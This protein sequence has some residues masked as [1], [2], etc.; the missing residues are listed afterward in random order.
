MTKTQPT[1]ENEK[2]CIE[3]LFRSERINKS[4]DPYPYFYI[5]DFLPKHLF[6]KIK[7]QAADF[8]KSSS[9]VMHGNRRYVLS[10]S[11]KFKDFIKKSNIWSEFFS[12]ISSQESF[13]KIIEILKEID[14]EYVQNNLFSHKSSVKE[15][16]SPEKHPFFSKI[17]KFKDIKLGFCSIKAIFAYLIRFI[18]RKILMVLKVNTYLLFNSVPVQLL[19]DISL[20]NDGYGREIHRDSDN[21]VVVFLFFMSD[22]AVNA[23]GGE[24]GMYSLKNHSQD[25]SFPPQPL[26]NECLLKQSIKPKSNR[27]VVFL[28]S[29][30]A[31]HDVKVMKGH[32]SSR[33]FI[34]GGFTSFG[35]S[36][37]RHRQV[38]KTEYNHYLI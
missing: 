35:K 19:A 6:E 22:H 8:V 37:L 26:G 34:Y 4:K 5:D 29:D 14:P 28:N 9:S 11:Y 23:E 38:L 3:D 7:T 2:I 16:I 15:V 20:A 12:K 31:Y 25:K 18:F 17:S 13:D 36:L 30:E 1:C 21:R 33:L 24:L 27:L 10:T 32:T